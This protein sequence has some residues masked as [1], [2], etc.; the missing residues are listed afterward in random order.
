MLPLASVFE[1]QKQQALK[2]RVER[3]SFR[4]ARLQKLKGWIIQH[5]NEIC[6]AVY[7]DYQKPLAENRL[8]EVMPVL[9]EIELALRELDNWAKPQKVDTP[10]LFLGTRSHIQFEPKGVCLILSPWNFPF[11]LCIGPLVSALAAG[12]TAILKPSELTPATS[13]LIA[14]M[15]GEVFDVREVAVAE[16][17][18][19]V[20]QQLLTFPFDHIF[21]TG[22]TAVGKIVMTAAAAHLCS[23]TL[24]LG[25]KSPA[26]ID[27]SVDV[28]DAARKIAWGK[29]INNGQVCISPD[30]LLVHHS[31]KEQMVEALQRHIESMFGEKVERLETSAYYGRIVNLRHFER[32]KGLLDDALAHGGQVR[33][34]GVCQIESRFI[35]PTLIDHIPMGAKIMQEEIFGPLLPIIAYESM[36]EALQIIASQ[37][38]PLAL[39]VFSK[40]S[41]VQKEVLAR[42]SSGAVVVNDCVL[43]FVHPYLPFGGV[44]HSGTGR[45][46]GKA[47]FLSFSNDKP[48]LKQRIGATTAHLLYPPYG[49]RNKWVVSL[50][51]K[52]G[53]WIG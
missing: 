6:Q 7:T 19:E 30:Y 33:I 27:A 18:V 17:G 5:E 2:Q 49:K 11:N 37:P 15:I 13:A 20:S 28:E 23:I 3:L 35:S 1:L 39:Y 42:T 4:K 51:N 40:N 36:E 52:L 48:V 22:S 16:G 44:N 9:L 14:R 50:V 10:L 29:F 21:F 31:V 8:T 43:H 38:K 45:S 26:L 25:G 12:N 46:H 47:G 53:K 34:G 41:S 32:I 24:E